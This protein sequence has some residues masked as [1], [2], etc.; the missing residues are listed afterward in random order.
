M[1][2]SEFL[3][4]INDHCAVIKCRDPALQNFGNI[5]VLAVGDL[6]Q[7]PPVMAPPIFEHSK[8]IQSLTDLAPL[9]W[10]KFQLHEITQIMRQKDKEFCNE[11]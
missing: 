10:D 11:Y 8:H 9:V 2:S 5:S 3:A 1:V 4:S 6:Y 7:L